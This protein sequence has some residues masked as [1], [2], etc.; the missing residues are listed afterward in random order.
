MI[1][2]WPELDSNAF[3]ASVSGQMNSYLKRDG[4]LFYLAWAWK[5]L[6]SYVYSG[7]LQYK[8]VAELSLRLMCIQNLFYR[9]SC[10]LLSLQPQV[11]SKT[12]FWWWT[13]YQI[14]LGLNL[15]FVRIIYKALLVS[16]KVFSSFA[17]DIDVIVKLVGKH[18]CVNDNFFTG[19]P[20]GWNEMGRGCVWVTSSIR[21]FG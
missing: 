8:C 4:M 2:K 10:F 14:Q 20:D 16:S 13:N 18:N 19:L 9:Y 11:M 3:V 12:D 6:S 21:S 1:L 7:R 15:F 5:L 17:V